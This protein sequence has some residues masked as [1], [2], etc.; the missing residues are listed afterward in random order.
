VAA[1]IA[2]ICLVMREEDYLDADKPLVVE[3]PVVLDP[4]ELARYKA[5]EK[6]LILELPE[7]GEVEAETGAA[8]G[9]KLMQYASGAVLDAER[10]V[11]HVHDRKLEEMAQLRE[12]AQGSPLLVAYW[13]RASLARLT[14][15][16]PMATV[17]DKE[18]RCLA[19]WNAGKINMLLIH[20][21]SAGHGLNMQLGPGHIL[22]F[23]DNPWPLELYMQTIKRLARPGQKKPVK[24]FHLV[25]RGT[26]DETVV[27]VLRAKED[28]QDTVR[29]YIRDLRRKAMED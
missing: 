24:V 3:R 4:A 29:K 20:P 22:V 7:G 15:L 8:L 27:P 1:K 16:F 23:F 13:H 9:Q 28:A 10:Q 19:D 26:L 17:M 12:E 5:F 18:A 11:H 14:K 25:T 6:N 21:A 2:D